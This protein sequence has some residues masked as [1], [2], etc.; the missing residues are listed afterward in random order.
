MVRNKIVYIP[1]VVKGSNEYIHNMI[2]ILKKNYQVT[3]DLANPIAIIQ[4]LHT[5]AVFLNW[6]EG[7]LS[8]EMKFQLILH[9][10]LGVK[11]VWVF[12]NR[13]PH[14]IGN[15]KHVWRNMLWL[16]GNSSV[17]V[18]HSKHS[19]K[20]IPNLKKNGR[21]AV[22][23]PH[24]SYR[25]SNQRKNVKHIKER[26]R[27]KED[28]FV[29][30]IIGFISPYK[31]IEGGISAF[32]Q[33]KNERTKLL[34]V[35]KPDNDDYASRIRQMCG[36]YSNII[37]DLR[38]VSNDTLESIIAIS[39]VIVMPYKNA[40]SMNSGVM[41]HAFSNGRTVIAPDICMAKD[42][43]REGFFYMYHEQSDLKKIMEK[44]YK[45]G[46]NINRA[47]GVTAKNYMKDNNSR[48]IVYEQLEK[49][50]NK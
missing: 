16:A 31:N 10:L 12:H 15:D 26:Y 4:M 39:D 23:I 13:K 21:K 18:L 2:K 47:M 24:I 30:S 3:G 5:K 34:I 45:N 14:D 36:D 50:L 9:K 43:S 8:F 1:F 20:Y 17:I 28:D 48:Q 19:K 25:E 44:A 7:N 27:I 38:Y 32:K 11:I 22:Y 46:R 37:L 42:I 41:I 40:S 29:F 49:I 33:L 35:G 6:V